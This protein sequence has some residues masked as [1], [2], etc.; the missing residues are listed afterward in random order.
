MEYTI[1][2]EAFIENDEE[3]LKQARRMAEVLRTV[4]NARTVRVILRDKGGRILVDLN[5]AA[6]F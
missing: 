4:P 2:V 6:S 1:E 3:A 5:Y